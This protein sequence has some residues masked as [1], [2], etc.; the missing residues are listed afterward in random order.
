MNN[1][2]MNFVHKFLYGHIFLFLLIIDVGMELLGNMVTLGL[3]FF[4]LRFFFFF[5]V[6]H[7]KSLY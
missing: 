2:F 6:D 5:D 7:Y 4:F 1:A 3:T